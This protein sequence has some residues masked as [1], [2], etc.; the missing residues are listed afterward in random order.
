MHLVLWDPDLL[1]QL[2]RR[3]HIVRPHHG[4]QPHHVRHSHLVKQ[5]ETGRQPYLVGHR[6]LVRQPHCVRKPLLVW[7]LQLMRQHHLV[8]QHYL[9]FHPHLTSIPPL[10]SQPLSAPLLIL[11]S[12]YSVVIEGVLHSWLYGSTD[13]PSVPSVPATISRS[14]IVYIYLFCIKTSMI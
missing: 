1:A 4:K 3:T 11:A 7:P 12:L 13:V 9:W 8:T 6:H 14:E 2:I 10:W 5:P